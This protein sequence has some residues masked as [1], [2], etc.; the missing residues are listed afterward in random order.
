M[1]NINEINNLLYDQLAILDR[2]EEKAIKDGAEEVIAQIKK[3][4]N[5][6]QLKLYQNPALTE[7]LKNK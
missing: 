6:I 3:E 4:R 2:I 7:E 1:S 5:W